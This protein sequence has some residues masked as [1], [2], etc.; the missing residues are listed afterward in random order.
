M[1]HLPPQGLFVF[2]ACGG[3][4]SKD[5][6]EGEG[7]IRA[8]EKA[9]PIALL[10]RPTRSEFF[11]PLPLLK[12]VTQAIFSRSL[13]IP[14]LIYRPT[15][16]GITPVHQ[17]ASEGHVKCLQ[18][19]I[20]SGAAIDTV[21]G[22]GH[23]PLSIARVWGHRECARI[24][25]NQQWYLDKQKELTERLQKE[26]ESKQLEEEMQKLSLIRMAEGRHESQLAFKRWMAEKHFPDIP[27]MYGP[28]PSEEREAAEEIRASQSLRPTPTPLVAES[29]FVVR[30]N[31][32]YESFDG[33]PA[34]ASRRSTD[35]YDHDSDK[36]LELIPLERISASKRRKGQRTEGLRPNRSRIKKNPSPISR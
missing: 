17:A 7:G 4:R 2:L 25:A 36:K 26:Q 15:H 11:L 13:I 33:V 24:L 1:P 18:E 34:F 28:V 35:Y 29:S 8:C 16:A 31:T 20:K 9:A 10:A 22:N 21:D 5:G 23:T 27:T 12:P 6:G 19:L 30:S 14:L 32:E 3:R